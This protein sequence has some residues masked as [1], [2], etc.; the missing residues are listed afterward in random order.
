MTK[1]STMRLGKDRTSTVR[2][3]SNPVYQSVVRD[4]KSLHN[5]V[6]NVSGQWTII[7]DRSVA[8][9]KIVIKNK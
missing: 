6:E 7:K 4:L 3:D 5:A 9:N 2:T 1:L 8:W